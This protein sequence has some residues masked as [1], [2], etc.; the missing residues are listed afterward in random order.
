MKRKGVHV[1]I[2]FLIIP[3]TN[4]DEGEIRKMTRYIVD[5]LGPETPLHLSRFFPLHEF[6]HVPQTP[7]RT[8]VKA[9]E[10]ALEEGVRYVFVGNV[11][12]QNYEHT[13]C[14]VCSKPVIERRGYDIE[15]WSLDDSNRCNHC[16][17]AIPII[18]TR[19]IHD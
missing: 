10:I 14:H 16:G 9:R 15:G 12:S 4:D 2:T 8:L 5:E 17:E 11:P 7:I 18:G 13:F 3:E 19:E 1:E 6:T